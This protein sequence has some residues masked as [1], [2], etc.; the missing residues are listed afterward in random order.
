[1]QEY[2]RH[3][4]G[5]PKHLM[6]WTWK[7]SRLGGV[8]FNYFWFE[9][10]LF[11]FAVL[12]RDQP[13]YAYMLTHGYCTVCMYYTYNKHS[14]TSKNVKLAIASDHIERLAVISGNNADGY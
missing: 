2:T 12:H 1:M 5:Y 9:L 11:S 10:S 4:L 6:S 3:S 7:S 8:F 13:A 14:T